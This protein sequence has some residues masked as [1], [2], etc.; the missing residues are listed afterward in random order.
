MLSITYRKLRRHSYRALYISCTYI[1]LHTLFVFP[2]LNFDLTSVTIATSSKGSSLTSRVLSNK[3][4]KQQQQR[5]ADVCIAVITGFSDVPRKGLVVRLLKQIVK[6][7]EELRINDSG[8][9]VTLNLTLTLSVFCQGPCKVELIDAVAPSEKV[10]AVME[11]YEILLP[12]KAFNKMS[13]EGKLKRDYDG[14]HIVISW[15]Y[16]K[17][18]ITLV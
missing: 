14:R 3:L 16:R 5:K 12:L 6:Q 4:I 8:T 13:D 2:S 7:L 15:N 1:V 18:N 11:F 17:V 10:K 9:A